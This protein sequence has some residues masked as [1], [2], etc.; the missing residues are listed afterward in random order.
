MGSVALWP[1]CWW[2]PRLTELEG[3]GR[4]SLVARETVVA[5]CLLA[6]CV[7]PHLA[8]KDQGSF[9]HWQVAPEPTLQ[10]EME[11]R[12]AG[13]VGYRECSAAQSAGVVEVFSEALRRARAVPQRQQIKAARAVGRGTRKSALNAL[14]ENAHNMFRTR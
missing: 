1:S 13:S 12:Y 2:A 7:C 4:S 6:L 10:H 11:R 14:V 3:S 8:A 9:R 5:P